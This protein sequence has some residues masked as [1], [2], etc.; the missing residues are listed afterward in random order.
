MNCH[1]LLGYSMSPWVYMS[2]NLLYLQIRSVIG[3]VHSL[4]RGD[5]KGRFVPL[6]LKSSTLKVETELMDDI[7]NGKRPIVLLPP[8]PRNNIFVL[9]PARATEC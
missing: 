5:P 2:R 4:R 6:S 8:V 7:N 9:D 3:L 1:R